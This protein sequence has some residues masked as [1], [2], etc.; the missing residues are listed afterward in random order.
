MASGMHGWAP[1]GFLAQIA[2]P[3]NPFAV[4]VAVLIGIPLYS[5]AAGMIPVVSELIRLGVP[6][7][8]ALAFMMSVTAVSLPETI[9]LRQVIK[10]QLIAIFLGIVMLSIIFTG[11]LFNFLLS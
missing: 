5:N 7:G 6:V 4:L 9:L 1:T 11:Y 10:P 3:G 8:T 2:G